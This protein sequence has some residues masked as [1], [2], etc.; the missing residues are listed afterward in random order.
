MLRRVG[1]WIARAVLGAFVI[2]QFAFV[3]GLNFCEVTRHY[4]GTYPEQVGEVSPSLLD[5][6]S[7][8]SRRLAKLEQVC[9][10][11]AEFTGQ[12]QNWSLFAP[13]VW[14]N[15]PFVAVEFRWDEEPANACAAAGLVAALAASEPLPGVTAWA[16]TAP[17]PPDYVLS[18]NE[19]RDIHC[20]FRVGRFRLRRFEGNIDVSLAVDPGKTDDDMLDKWRTSIRNRVSAEALAVRAYLEWRWQEYQAA[21]PD[22][23]TPKQ[24]IL[25]VRVYRIPLPNDRQP[26]DWEGPVDRP[27][28]RWRPHFLYPSDGRRIEAYDLIA[29][30]Y[31]VLP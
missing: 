23:E 24:V 27:M 1:C 4:V 25:H 13:D 15:T 6:E 17:R 3:V 26:W 28:A 16:A 9:T 31:D 20:Y 30:R 8:T 12:L 22:V 21:H 29:E 10:R 7:P 19:P 11:W 18:D 2:W 5:A 14:A